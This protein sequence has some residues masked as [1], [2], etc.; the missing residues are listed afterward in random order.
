MAR[1]LPIAPTNRPSSNIK[2]SRGARENTQRDNTR[3]SGRQKNDSKIGP[4]QFL[5]QSLDVGQSWRE[6]SVSPQMCTSNGS[7]AKAAFN[8]F[9]RFKPS[10]DEAINARALSLRSGTLA[11]S[12]DEAG[13]PIQSRS[14]A[15]TKGVSVCDAAEFRFETHARQLLAPSL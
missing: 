10:D 12:S 6:N 7:V 8:A 9:A 5:F 15:Q 3:S 2:L 4:L 13:R 1:R 14:V 11:A